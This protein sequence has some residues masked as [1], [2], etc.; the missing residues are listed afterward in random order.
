MKL[1]KWKKPT[2]KQWIFITGGLALLLIAVGVAAFFL[3]R[4]KDGNNLQAPPQPE[5]MSENVISASGL[6]SVGMNTETL[7]LNF[8]DTELYVE[9]S[10]LSIGD[11]VEEG[12]K[13]FKIS[14]ETLEEAKEE[15]Q[16][17]VTKAQ[18]AYRQGVI[19]YETDMLEAKS[20]YETALVEANYAQA[21]YEEAVAN[22]KQ[23]V[24]EL[25]DQVEEAQELVDEYEKS[26]SEDYY[27]DYYQVDEL[28][29]SYYEHF[30]LLMTYYE[31]WDVEKLNDLYGKSASSLSLSSLTG[32]GTASSA[33][34]G[35]AAAS[36]SGTATTSGTASKNSLTSSSKSTS[37]SSSAS[38]GGA[39]MKTAASSG[40]SNY[41]AM[42]LTTGYSS[43]T[44]DAVVNL[45]SKVSTQNYGV[46]LLAEGDEPDEGGN[47]GE[48]GGSGEGGNQG[49]DGG[50]GE[51]PSFGDSMP[52]GMS[53]GDMT[54]GAAVV[55]NE[56]LKLS[57]YNLLDELVTEEAEAYQTAKDNYET[58]KA[59]AKASLTKAKSNLEDL[60]A[61][62][63][64]A[65]TTYEKALI[66]CKADYET[67]LAESE[68]AETV[69][70]TTVQSLE[71][72]L[73]SLKDDKEEAEENQA[74]F[75]EALGDGYFYT[76]KAGTI[77]MNMIR[78]DS[79]LSGDTM[80]TAYSNPETVTI[81]ASVDQSDIANIS[82]GED[83]YVVIEEYGNYDG[84]VTTINPVTQADSRT[85]VTYQV[86]VTLTGDISNL[87]SN[88]TAYVYFGDVESL[89]QMTSSVSGNSTGVEVQNDAPGNLPENGAPDN[90][91]ENGTTGGGP[92]GQDSSGDTA[93]DHMQEGGPTAQ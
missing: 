62:L 56:S 63:T 71:E 37:G 42:N 45:A 46:I 9:E 86:T 69:Y 76:E 73:E 87:D 77:V 2:K 12:T 31:N 82:I 1:K 4:K 47:E 78:V 20:A 34:S 54:G 57:V 18:L 21:E 79:Y 83:A 61:Q 6:T 38:S 15:L 64:E 70:N 3:L 41:A 19:D 25:E 67:T 84:T 8:L 53:M 50:S 28:Y 14:D 36:S 44:Y 16:N 92:G 11:E 85:S 91:P 59:T 39:I 30:N 66:T 10:Y 23:T 26:E 51:K 17:T 74:S 60:Q 90:M 93:P 33:M 43:G 35:A 27:R 22:A 75:L 40:S 58:A 68:N 89:K 81:A 49:E 7:K 48:G 72:T 5:G 32:S 88:L 29:A 65:Q 52:S 80:V 55:D 13:V 24:D